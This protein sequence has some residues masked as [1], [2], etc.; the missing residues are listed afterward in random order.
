MSFIH[1]KLTQ[2]VDQSR[3]ADVIRG[4]TNTLIILQMYRWKCL[5]GGVIPFLRRAVLSCSGFKESRILVRTL[6]AVGTVACHDASW[7]CILQ[8]GVT[9][10]LISTFAC[11][12]AVVL[13]PSMSAFRRTSWRVTQEATLP[14][15][16]VW[17]PK[18]FGWFRWN[19]I[20]NGTV[21]TFNVVVIGWIYFRFHWPSITTLHEA[22]MLPIDKVD[23][24]EV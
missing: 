8:Q 15:R 17:T 12:Y 7:F 16:C 3:C 22:L 11:V 4:Y 14:R 5:P 6:Q 13:G 18:S 2:E 9:C 10:S 1:Q 21:H 19:L 20:F 24:A 23:I